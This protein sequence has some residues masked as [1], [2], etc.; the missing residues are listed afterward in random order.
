MRK[1]ELARMLCRHAA[2]LA[3][4]PAL[5]HNLFTKPITLHETTC[6]HFE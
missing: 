6:I 5:L 3:Y 2:S 1:V 4:T